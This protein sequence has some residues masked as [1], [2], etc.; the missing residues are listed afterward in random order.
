MNELKAGR[1]F[2]I[3]SGSSLDGAGST[4]EEIA[5]HASKSGAKFL[6]IDASN[7]AWVDTPG[8]RW[9]LQ[10]RS[11]LE[12]MGKK[13]RIVSRSQ[14]RVSRNLELLNVQ[15]DRFDTVAGA[16]K[17]PWNSVKKEKR[18]KKAA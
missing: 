9:L 15:I 16:W 14:S 7:A 13:L 1:V 10:L 2:L 18:H 17:T 11:N 4:P 3:R 6:I 12:A 8:I 5:S